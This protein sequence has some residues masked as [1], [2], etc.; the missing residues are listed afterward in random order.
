MTFKVG[1]RVRR[2]SGSNSTTPLG[3][4]GVIREVR[5]PNDDPEYR[6]DDGAWGYD[7]TLGEVRW[8]LVSPVGPVRTVTRTVTEVV[9]GSYGRVRV[10][11]VVN[12]PD[13]TNPDVPPAVVVSLAMDDAEYSASELKAAAA[14]LLELAGALE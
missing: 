13:C 12:I 5:H 4:E 1:D 8:E 7:A 10:G 14:V 6:F 11:R 2:I 3:F 9:A